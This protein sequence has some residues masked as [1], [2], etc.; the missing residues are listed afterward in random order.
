VGLSRSN[1]RQVRVIPLP[2]LSLVDDFS[3]LFFT[4]YNENITSPVTAISAWRNQQNS[5][6]VLCGIE[7]DSP[8]ALFNSK[9]GEW[10]K[11][12]I[13]TFD[14]ASFERVFGLDPSLVGSI[15]DKLELGV[16]LSEL[17]NKNWT[18]IVLETPDVA[19]A[20]R[21]GILGK[22]GEIYPSSYKKDKDGNRM[23]TKSGEPIFRKSFLKAYKPELKDVYYS[24]PVEM[25]E[26]I[27]EN[28]A[29]K[30]VTE[31][32]PF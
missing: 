23:L 12:A 25:V 29:K 16:N 17:S 14:E 21:Y 8:N 19:T 5:I 15:D 7:N 6:S 9:G 13:Q 28:K 1:W 32:A 27:Q 30:K 2:S 20:T 31:E 22:N 18:I 24:D 4:M 10:I 26:M 11:T 3:L